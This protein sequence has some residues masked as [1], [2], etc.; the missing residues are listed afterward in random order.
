M[1]FD[2]IVG[3][4]MLIALLFLERAFPF[5]QGRNQRLRHGLRNGSLAVINGVTTLAAV[6]L[7]VVAAATS[8]HYQLGLLHWFRTPSFVSTILVGALAL[9][10]LDLW[11]YVWHRAN[12]RLPLLWRFHQVHHTDPA[13]DATTALRFHPGE[14]FLSSLMMP[15]VVLVLGVGL[16][17]LTLYKGLMLAVI[18]LHHSNL[19]LPDDVEVKLSRLIV[20]PSMHRVH[21]S[22]IRR[23]TDS[24]YGSVLSCWDRAFGTYRVRHDLASIRFGTGYRDG[25]AWQSLGQ[26]LRLPLLRSQRTDGAGA[27]AISDQRNGLRRAA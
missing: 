19:A 9:L 12:H 24:N 14:L 22:R 5:Y 25:P 3:L 20:P 18:L 6:P 23:E 15:I 1:T 16:V 17:E 4:S 13:M 27:P 7:L 26:L 11:M 2:L 21:H 10:L 8:E